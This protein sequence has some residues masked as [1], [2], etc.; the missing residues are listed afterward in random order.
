MLGRSAR[1]TRYSQC[2]RLRGCGERAAQKIGRG[3]KERIRRVAAA[4][5][6][7]HAAEAIISNLS[8]TSEILFSQFLTNMLPKRR[9]R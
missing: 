9:F 7:R 6:G 2:L 3:R 8:L 1:A 5:M 4:R